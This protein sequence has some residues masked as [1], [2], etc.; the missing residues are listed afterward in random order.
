MT[1]SHK[2]NPNEYRFKID[3]YSPETMPLPVLIEYLK[4]V[5]EIL[6]EDHSTHLIRIEKGSTCPVIKIDAEAVPKIHKRAEEIKT[7]DAPPKVIEAFNRLTQRLRNDNAQSGGII[8]PNGENLIVFPVKETPPLGYGP[9]N[10]QGVI[11]G[12]PVMIGGTREQVPIHLEGRGGETYVCYTNRA[13]AKRIAAHFFTTIIRA[14]GN[15]RWIRHA[16]GQWEMK[17]FKITDFT[18]LTDESNISLRK[19]IDKIRAIPAKWK[20]LSDPV[21]ELKRIRYGS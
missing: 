9:F 10:Q 5:A 18:P 7:G 15:G 17:T 21:A 19:S 12:I 14:E 8:S 13:I 1:K 2:S 4:D 6:G 11:D 16:E 3:A 20:E